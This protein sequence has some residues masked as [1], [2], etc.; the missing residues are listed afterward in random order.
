MFW[1]NNCGYLWMEK[2][3]VII[4]GAGAAGLMA[5]RI[6]CS[7]GKKVCILEAR[8]RIGGRVHTLLKEGFSR[9]VEGGGEFIHGTLPLTISLLKEA[10]IKYYETDGELWQLQNNEL[11]KREDFI[12]HADQLMK[13][14]K[15]LDHDISIAELLQKYF[16]DEKY[17]DMKR[18][19][20]QY[21]EGYDAADIN[22]ASSL[23]LK[24][25]WE[26]EDDEQYRIE[27]GYQPLLEYLKNICLRNGCSIHLNSIVKKIKWDNAVEVITNENTVFHSDKNPRDRAR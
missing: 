27:G 8:D 17:A 6:L 25:E 20:Q 11:K 2:F 15:E 18:S 3:D 16:A 24:E 12:E 22:Y 1:Q 26:K 7:A 9:S 10:G 14:L 19:L 23:A 5:A 4:V 21:I 13:K